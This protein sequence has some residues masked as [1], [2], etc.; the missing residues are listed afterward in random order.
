MY[1]VDTPIRSDTYHRPTKQS[2]LA[3]E[4]PWFYLHVVTAHEIC[5]E[6]RK[7]HR[8]GRR[9]K[10]RRR[11]RRRR[12]GGNR[13]KGKE[14]ERKRTIEGVVRL[15]VPVSMIGA[16]GEWDCFSAHIRLRDPG[17]SEDKAEYDRSSWRVELLQ[18][19]YSLKGARQVRGQSRVVKKGEEAM[20]SPVGLSYP[21]SKASV[22]KEVDSEEHYSATE[23]D[24]PIAKKGMQM[25]V[26][27]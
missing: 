2:R 10:M 4:E 23:A 22:R 13:G 26:N 15:Q 24:L 20:T 18:C 12:R 27:G 21:K 5:L 19:S 6:A 17:K 11:G 9:K 7:G 25:Q 14:K 16:A 3:L 8:R 1:Y